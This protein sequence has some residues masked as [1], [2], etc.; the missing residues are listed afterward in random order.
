MGIFQPH[1]SDTA[2]SELAKNRNYHYYL[3]CVM[4]LFRLLPRIGLVYLSFCLNRPLLPTHFGYR[5]IFKA[6]VTLSDTNTHTNMRARANGRIPLEEGSALCR[7]V[8]L[9]AHNTYKRQTSMPLA[10]FEAAIPASQWL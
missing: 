10:G 6:L 4:E 3:Q 1:K 5:G 8:Y 9:T 7:D 2:H